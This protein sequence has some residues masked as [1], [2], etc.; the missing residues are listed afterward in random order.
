MRT[1]EFEASLEEARLYPQLWRLLLGLLLIGFIFATGAA[2]LMGAFVAVVNQIDSMNA[3]HTGAALNR[4]RAAAQGYGGIDT[5]LAV[6]LLLITFIALFIGPMLSAA[7]FH[8]RGPGSLF[9]PTA[10]WFRG[11]GTALAVLVPIYLGLVWLSFLFESP[12][13]NLPFARWLSYLPFA[14][15][16]IF[17][18]T[19]AEELLFRGYLQQQLAARFAARWIWMG[20]PSLVFAGL[21]WSQASGDTLPFVLLS[22]LIFGLIAADI[23]EQTGNLGAAMGIHFGNNLFGMLGVALGE[24]VSGLAL[25]VSITPEGV[26]SSLIAGLLFSLAMLVLVWWITRRLLTR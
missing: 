2:M 15:P 26:S 1:G 18:Q 10:D 24:S 8:F 20:L 19:A 3:V 17:I 23:T 22:A 13:P 7:A 9:G 25:F 14:I 5:P 6:F 12:Q 21:H 11:F 4:L 16:L